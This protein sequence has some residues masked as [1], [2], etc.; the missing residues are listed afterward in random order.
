[1][2][3]ETLHEIPFSEPDR[4]PDK[5]AFI[6]RLHDARIEAGMRRSRRMATI[7][8][9]A[10]LIVAGILSFSG[11]SEERL[12]QQTSALVWSAYGIND[13]LVT[14]YEYDLALY[15]IDESEDIYSTIEFLESV[16]YQPL[17]AVMEENHE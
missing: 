8:A 17:T 12:S 9:F 1:M 13:S 4:F 16:N 6:N 7:Q 10:V 3:K 11:L 14:D 5:T 2:E 15:L